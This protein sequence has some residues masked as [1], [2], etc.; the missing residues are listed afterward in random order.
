[1]IAHTEINTHE[2][3]EFTHIRKSTGQTE[4]VFYFEHIILKR[5]PRNTVSGSRDT[6]SLQ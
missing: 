3:T 4:I 1:M 6:A 2:W 5:G